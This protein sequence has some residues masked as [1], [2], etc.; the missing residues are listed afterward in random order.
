MLLLALACT[1]LT[2]STPTD[3]PAPPLFPADALDFVETGSALIE[4]LA[5]GAAD[6]DGDGDEE[7]FGSD[8][9][10]ILVW[11][12]ADGLQPARTFSDPLNELLGVESAHI[13]QIDA[14][15]LDGDGQAEFVLSVRI[16]TNDEVRYA[17]VELG[18]QSEMSV[19]AED[20]F[21]AFNLI[22]DLDGDQLPELV[23]YGQ[24]ESTIEFSDGSAIWLPPE[25]GYAFFPHAVSV[26]EGALL[27]PDNGCGSSR[28]WLISTDGE[29]LAEHDLDIYD[30]PLT[31]GGPT[32]LAT[33]VLVQSNGLYRYVDGEFLPIELDGSTPLSVGQFDAA[34]G[35][36]L[37]SRGAED[38]FGYVSDQGELTA[39]PVAGLH[40]NTWGAQ[41]ADLNGDGLDDLVTTEY[42]QD[43]TLIRVFENRSRQ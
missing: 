14:A 12:F 33:E 13:H 32:Q 40:Q 19:L 3:E 42:T 36:D 38:I 41:S 26:P 10:R 2:S 7:I 25:F 31:D 29:I 37:L 4:G 39:V 18:Q 35:A 22:A 1:P 17:L 20:R 5:Q 28:S 27:F 24:E 43:G 30:A 23:I 11:D 16:S 34:E 15:D 6:L 21:L 8:L 9:E